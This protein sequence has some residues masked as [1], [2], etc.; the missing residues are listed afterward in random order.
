M[1]SEG[2]DEDNAK[3]MNSNFHPVKNLNSLRVLFLSADP[4]TTSSS[5][6]SL[7]SLRDAAAAGRGTTDGPGFFALRSRLR[8]SADSNGPMRRSANLRIS[9]SDGSVQPL[10]GHVV[11][12]EAE[13]AAPQVRPEVPVMFVI[14]PRCPRP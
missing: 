5:T 11:G 2:G 6:N 12:D 9:S 7:N 14:D 4:S 1:A 13:A 10:Q 8:C 3:I